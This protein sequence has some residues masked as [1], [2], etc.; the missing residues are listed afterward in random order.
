MVK[1]PG[2]QGGLPGFRILGVLGEL[3]V[4]G[5]EVG[6]GQLREEHPEA[7]Q[8][9]AL[10]QGF[11]PLDIMLLV[12]PGD[13]LHHLVPCLGQAEGEEGLG[14]VGGV[15]AGLVLPPLQP[16]VA[17]EGAHAVVR[18]LVQGGQKVL[19]PVCGPEGVVPLEKGL[20]GEGETPLPCGIGGDGD[21]VP[22]GPC[23]GLGRFRHRRVLGGGFC[24]SR[25]GPT[26]CGSTGHCQGQ[27][28]G[29]GVP[30]IVCHGKASPFWWA[31]G[32]SHHWGPVLGS[33]PS[34]RPNRWARSRSAG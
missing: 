23:W 15:L 19:P 27:Q 30:F 10:K 11:W 18:P 8:G 17:G 14:K 29:G 31:M 1:H 20:G 12:Q 5:L 21:R 34:S 32:W 22:G 16:A 24:G 25:R 6:L 26:A 9:L 4:E 28:E 3:G 7:V 13:H 33:G 2:G